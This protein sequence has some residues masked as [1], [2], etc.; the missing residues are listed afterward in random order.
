MITK[1][2]RGT[3]DEWQDSSVVPAEGE[4]V[5]E[6]CDN[7]SRKFKIGDGRRL[8][9]ELPYTDEELTAKLNVAIA[10]V[11]ELIALKEGDTDPATLDEVVDIRTG[12]DGVTYSTAGEA[13]RAIGSD[14]ADLRKSLQQFINADAVDGLL[15][16]NNMLYLTA[17]G[18]IVS[19]PVEILVTVCIAF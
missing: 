2:R 12:Y 13:V 17:A 6:E 3:T 14:T 16:E 4:I 9:T 5:I 19:E 7:G 1:H 10:R 11:N 18:V 8:F 15:Y